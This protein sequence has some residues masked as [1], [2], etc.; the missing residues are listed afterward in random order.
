VVY[1]GPI[2]APIAK[3]QEIARLQVRTA[4]GD[5]QAMP[6]VAAEEVAAVGFF[7]RLWNGLV[8]LFG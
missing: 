5:V 1:N 4:D 2:K 7:G 6:L 8:S 3:G